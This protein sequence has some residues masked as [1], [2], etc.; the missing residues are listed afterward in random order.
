M[1]WALRRHELP[2]YD[3]LVTPEAL[4][5]SLGFAD[6]E[7][8]STLLDHPTLHSPI[9]LEALR[10]QLLGLHW[11]LRDY[12]LRPQAMDFRAFARDCWFGPLD[13]TPFRLVGS[14]L[15]LGDYAISDAP[16]EVFQSALSAATERH[17]AINWLTSGGIYSQTDT[18]T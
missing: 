9:E 2:E 12:T 16:E 17:Q 4:I 10:K 1:A 18:S 13:I 3:Q 8:A 14:D 7:M 15:A 6:V 11:R 5:S